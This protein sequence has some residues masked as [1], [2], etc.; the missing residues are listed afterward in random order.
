VTSQ[1]APGPLSRPQEAPLASGSQVY[2]YVEEFDSYAHKAYARDV[3]W[4]PTEQRLSLLP[5]AGG[6]HRETNVAPDGRGGAFVAWSDLR[7]NERN[8]NWDIYAQHV[9]GHGNRLWATDLRVN[10]DTGAA[11]Q[12]VPALVADTQGN[13]LVAWIDDR[14][15][16]GAVYAQK[17]SRSGAKLWPADVRVD[18][19]PVHR[20][21]W[22]MATVQVALDGQD[23]LVVAWQGYREGKPGTDIYAQK[24]RPGGQHLWAED[25]QVN[26]DVGSEQKWVGLAADQDGYTVLAWVDDR[27]G[28]QDLYVQRLNPAGGRTWTEDRPASAGSGRARQGD[29]SV[30]LDSQGRAV[31]VWRSGPEDPP[32]IARQVSS[33][34]RNSTK[35]ERRF[36]A[37]TSASTRTIHLRSFAAGREPSVS[38]TSAR[39]WFGKIPAVALAWEQSISMRRYWIRKVRAS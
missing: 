9:D 33:V 29:P 3:D 12:G 26:E 27:H 13:L 17:L 10:S 36:G 1:L 31:I 11:Y 2:T 39:S 22:G 15:L 8:A 5:M 23:N 34:P 19:D 4:N 14:G 32:Q 16:T 24:L 18:R 35:T 30:V 7:N 20:A 6:A 21:G 37:A 25:V 38:P 28:G